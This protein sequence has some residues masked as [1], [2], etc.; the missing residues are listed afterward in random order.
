MLRRPMA[1]LAT[2]VT[3]AG[4]VTALG[5]ATAVAAPTPPWSGPSRAIAGAITNSTPAVS[6]VDCPSPI[7]NG[8][9]IAWRGR[10]TNE[11]IYYKFRTPQTRRWSTL[12]VIPGAATNSAPAIQLYEGGN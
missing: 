3:A 2:A 12:G 9:I 7:G 5:A 4:V 6:S 8:T 10:G 11:H 1:R